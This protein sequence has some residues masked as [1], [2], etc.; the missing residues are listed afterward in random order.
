VNKTQ[1]FDIRNDPLEMND[2]SGDSKNAKLIEQL[3]A[4][5]KRWQKRAG[6]DLDLEN[7]PALP[8][9]EAGKGAAGAKKAGKK[10]TGKITKAN[11]TS[12]FPK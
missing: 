12:S 10:K 4:D 7:P 2:L 3:N 8:P 6:D 9:P 11:N 5:L 1:L